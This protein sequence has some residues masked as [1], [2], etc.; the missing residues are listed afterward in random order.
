MS[1]VKCPILSRFRVYLYIVSLSFSQFSRYNH[2][3]Q[4]LEKLMEMMLLLT[5]VANLGNAISSYDLEKI[6]CLASDASTRS[7]LKHSSQKALYLLDK[8]KRASNVM[9][10]VNEEMV[11][12]Y[13]DSDEEDEDEK[14]KSDSTSNEHPAIRSERD[15]LTPW[16]GIVSNSNSSDE[17]QPMN[18]LPMEETYQ[19]SS[20][21]SEDDDDGRH[22]RTRTGESNL[23][24]LLMENLEP[25][26]SSVHEPVSGLLH[27][28]S[29]TARITSLLDGWEEPVNKA[30][31]MVL[32][33]A[34][35]CCSISNSYYSTIH[36]F[37]V[38]HSIRPTL[39]F[40]KYCGSER[41]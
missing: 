8:I 25:P 27:D 7:G 19:L 5:E 39:P 26:V 32:Y 23:T 22:H 34:S 33:I 2:Y 38:I 16:H 10:G 28:V 11:T 20:A 31:K 1:D 12:S 18:K 14:P 36:L 15:T 29:T 24:E 40:T 9:S 17:N 35:V 37:Y 13:S 4:R 41:L 21:L 3:K 6:D 30:D